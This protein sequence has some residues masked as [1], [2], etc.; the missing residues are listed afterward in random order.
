MTLTALICD[1]STGYFAYWLRGG[2]VNNMNKGKEEEKA[3]IEDT[4]ECEYDCDNRECLATGCDRYGSC[5]FT[6]HA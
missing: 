6:K 4:P 2:C 3:R 1:V 5:V